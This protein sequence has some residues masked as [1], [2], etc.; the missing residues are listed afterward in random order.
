MTRRI[1]LTFVTGLVALLTLASAA[2]AQ[3]YPPASGTLA[4]NKSQARP[5]ESIT[6]S[7]TEC[8]ANSTVTVTFDNTQV[9]TVQSGADGSFTTS[10]A[11]PSGASPGAHTISATCVLGNGT[12]RRQSVAVEVLGAAQ[13]GALPRT[14]ND[15]TTPLALGAATLI[16]L[17]G[18]AVIAARRR[19]A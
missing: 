5:G 9:G 8:P 7:G 4:A 16:G 13:A 12:T 15:L 19:R 17:G 3:Q 11:V 10:V 2:S 6:I 14:G 18:I 1:A